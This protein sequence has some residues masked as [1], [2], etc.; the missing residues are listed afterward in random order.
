MHDP[1]VVDEQ[2]LARRQSNAYRANDCEFL[3]R[4]AEASECLAPLLVSADW[5]QPW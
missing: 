3:D 1:L 2:H 4:A 5:F